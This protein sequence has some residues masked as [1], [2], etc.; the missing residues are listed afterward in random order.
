MHVNFFIFKQRSEIIILEIGRAWDNFL[1]FLSW[2]FYILSETYYN[3]GWP[4]L[5][6]HWKHNET[7][8][9]GIKKGEKLYETK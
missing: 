8:A 4:D 2:V 7:K 6:Q 1:F 3:K 5:G 9:R